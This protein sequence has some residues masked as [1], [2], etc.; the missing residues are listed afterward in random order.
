VLSAQPGAAG[1]SQLTSL[2]VRVVGCTHSH[3]LP[4]ACLPLAPLLLEPQTLYYV[5]ILVHTVS[6]RPPPPPPPPPT[7]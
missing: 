1:Q 5:Y 7:L 3:A 2:A 6:P 4:Q